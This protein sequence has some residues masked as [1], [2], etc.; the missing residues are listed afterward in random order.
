MGTP[1][2]AVGGPRSR[3]RG[4]RRRSGTIDSGTSGL[5]TGRT[6]Y[7]RDARSPTPE[8]AHTMVGGGARPRRRPV[9]R[10][11]VAV[12]TAARRGTGPDR[13]TD[14]LCGARRR[15]DRSWCRR[16]LPIATPAPA[17]ID[18]VARRPYVAVRPSGCAT[19]TYR[20]PATTPLNVTTPAAAATTRDPGGR[21]V[22]QPSIAR[23]VRARRRPERVRRPATIDG[24]LVTARAPSRS[25]PSAPRSRSRPRA[26][27]R[28]LGDPRGRQP[29][30]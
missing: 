6:C 8:A 22:L 2:S 19:T 27:T 26:A 29:G 5:T 23:T 11:R 15:S 17:R 25:G 14:H 13:C 4:D 18:A 28:V 24:R 7:R 20:T 10:A 1:L 30:A 12:D 3:R 21:F 9:R 16:R